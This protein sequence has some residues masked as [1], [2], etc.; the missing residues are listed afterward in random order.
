[1]KYIIQ[2]NN[3]YILSIGTGKLGEE[4]SET[5]YNEILVIIR[6][7]PQ[8]TEIIGYRLKEDLAWESYE[9]ELQ[10]Q[11]EFSDSEILSILLGGVS[12]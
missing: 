2:K 4:I 5:Q 6:N 12:S 8:E 7:K 9:K 1:M 11:H 10:P 3:G